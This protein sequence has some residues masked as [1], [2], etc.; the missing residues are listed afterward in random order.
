MGQ[1][2]QLLLLLVL[3]DHKAMSVRLV[4]Q[5]VREVWAQLGQLAIQ[6]GR[7]LT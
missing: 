7:S 6:R 2:K 4:P 3:L 5:E 1:P